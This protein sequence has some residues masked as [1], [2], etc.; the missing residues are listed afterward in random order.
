MY[1]D[2]GHYGAVNGMGRASSMDRCD[3]VAASVAARF[4]V[5]SRQR[6]GGFLSVSVGMWAQAAPHQGQKRGSGCVLG[7]YS[8][9]VSWPLAG[10]LLAG[11]EA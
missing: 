4:Q 9:L 2:R 7:L 11:A 6:A 1:V 10:Y 3:H 8:L 5:G